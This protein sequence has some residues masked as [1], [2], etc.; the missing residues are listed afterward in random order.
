MKRRRRRRRWRR[1]NRNEDRVR[2]KTAREVEGAH[3]LT[4]VKNQPITTVTCLN[5]SSHTTG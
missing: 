3:P 4:L 2:R 1:R 5:S